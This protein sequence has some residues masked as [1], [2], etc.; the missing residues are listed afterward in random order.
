MNFILWSLLIEFVVL[1]E[2][3]WQI[4]II[5]ACEH[6]TYRPVES[7]CPETARRTDDWARVEGATG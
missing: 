7:A 6:V 5:L 2:L 3:T 4:F 1:L